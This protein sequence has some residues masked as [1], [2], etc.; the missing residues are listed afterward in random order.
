MDGARRRWANARIWSRRAT[1]LRQL[2]AGKRA[3]KQVQLSMNV[4]GKGSILSRA[5]EAGK[6]RRELCMAILV[7]GGAGYIGGHM[8]LALLD[9]G[10]EVVVL[11]DLSTGF[12][13]AVPKPATLIV[14]DMGDKEKL[15]EIFARHKIEA[16]AHFAAKIVVPEF[17]LRSAPLL[18]QQHGQSPQ[19]DRSR[20]RRPNPSFHLF[21]NCRRLW[22]ANRQSDHRRGAARADQSLWPIETDGRMDAGGCRQ[23]ERFLLCRAPLFQCRRRRSQ[24]PAWP[25]YF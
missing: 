21:I 9:A 3:S 11:D 1:Q 7:T 5:L 19:S 4:R 12:S 16:I 18:S 17:G 2:V 23:G 13:W 10:E 14:G 24:G 25:I 8:V 22:R 15:A 20:H 6:R